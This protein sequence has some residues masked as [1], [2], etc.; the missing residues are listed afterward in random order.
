MKKLLLITAALSLFSVAQANTS[1]STGG[2]A[3][4]N[5]HGET[6]TVT[7]D[8]FVYLGEMRDGFVI[9]CYKFECKKI[10][11]DEK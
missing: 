8:G 9:V 1:S 3:A 2:S 7:A 4:I 10:K 5:H 6:V 11:V